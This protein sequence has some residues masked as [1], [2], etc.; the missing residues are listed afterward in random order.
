M[1]TID[2]HYVQGGQGEMIAAA[3]ARLALQP[4]PAVTRLGVT[5]LPECGTNDEVLQHH[6]LD[7]AS[8]A[9]RF[10]AALEP[11]AAR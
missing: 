8:L 1:I 10:R 9:Q 6:G 2:N 4:A 7:V 5:S 3:I 11:V